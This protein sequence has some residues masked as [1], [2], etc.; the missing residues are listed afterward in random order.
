MKLVMHLILKVN[1][2]LKT[3]V[4]YKRQNISPRFETHVNML[5]AK[6]MFRPQ[7]KITVSKSTQKK[8]QSPL[9]AMVL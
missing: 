5:T 8:L 7:N 1:L 9:S 6:S 3:L 4:S 2:S